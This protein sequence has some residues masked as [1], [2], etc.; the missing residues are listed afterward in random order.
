MLWKLLHGKSLVNERR[1][2]IEKSLKFSGIVRV[3]PFEITLKAGDGIS[4]V[5]A[6]REMMGVA[7][8]AYENV[9]C[10]IAIT[11]SRND[12]GLEI[13]GEKFEVSKGG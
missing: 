6:V 1:R 7:I 5:G 8:D 3:T 11:M 12:E 2:K 9:P 10:E 13:N 4:L